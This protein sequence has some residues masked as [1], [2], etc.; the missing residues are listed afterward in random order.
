MT[1]AFSFGLLILTCF[2]LQNS[3]YCDFLHFECLVSRSKIVTATAH[4]GEWSKSPIYMFGQVKEKS[5]CT[6]KK[7]IISSLFSVRTP[8]I[9][10]FSASYIAFSFTAMTSSDGENKGRGDLCK[11]CQRYEKRVDFRRHD[12]RMPKPLWKQQNHNLGYSWQGSVLET[13]V[14]AQERSR[15]DSTQI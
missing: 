5:R 8:E 11:D 15:K 2:N 10:I 6:L 7:H 1:Y 3:I 4:F 9:K 14:Q 12:C 13:T